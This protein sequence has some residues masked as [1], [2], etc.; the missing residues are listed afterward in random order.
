MNGA[1]KWIGG[2]VKFIKPFCRVDFRDIIWILSVEKRRFLIV[3][4][5][6]GHCSEQFFAACQCPLFNIQVVLFNKQGIAVLCIA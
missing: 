4:R 2:T 3:L 6:K 5:T 1:M